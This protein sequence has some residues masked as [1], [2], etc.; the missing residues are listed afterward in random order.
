MGKIADFWTMGGYGGFIWPAYG[1]A[2]VILVWLALHS[3]RW[4][5]AEE[6]EVAAMEA[7]APHRR[8]AARGGSAPG[9]N[10]S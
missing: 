4:L 1:L 3:L 6:R 2:L 7:D 5:R 8:A 9:E 10:A